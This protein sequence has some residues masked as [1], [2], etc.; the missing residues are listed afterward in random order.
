MLVSI[1]EWGEGRT[2]GERRAFAL[3]LRDGGERVEVGVMDAASSLWRDAKIVGRILDRAEALDNP[4][5]QEAFHIVDHALV[6]D[7]PLKHYFDQ[8]RA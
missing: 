7:G 3:E 4:L 2:P 8:P 5:L 1:G 6:E